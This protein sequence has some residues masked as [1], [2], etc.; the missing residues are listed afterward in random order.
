MNFLEY[1][2]RGQAERDESPVRHIEQVRE[3]VSERSQRFG[4]GWEPL[5]K[6]LAEYTKLVD[7]L[8]RLLLDQ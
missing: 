6:P 3:L 2:V 1:G 5:G 8:P 7:N 4:W